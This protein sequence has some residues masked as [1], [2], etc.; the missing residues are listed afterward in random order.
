MDMKKIMRGFRESIPE[1]DDRTLQEAGEREG[2]QNYK[3]ILYIKIDKEANIDVRQ[4]FGK[5]RAIPGVTTLRQ[6]RSIVD[7]ISYWLC[8][9]TVKFNTRG[10]PNKNY[11]YEVL[12]RQINSELELQGIPG[13][14]V[15]GINWQAFAEI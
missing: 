10:L 13:C 5:I 12:V 3:I 15:Y 11:I 14:K 6:E 8:E 9:I 1:Y 4:A 7:K 2:F